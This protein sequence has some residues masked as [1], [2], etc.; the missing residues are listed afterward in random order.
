M[1]YV[2]L[3]RLKK[4]VSAIATEQLHVTYLYLPPP[5]M[6]KYLVSNTSP[7]FPER[8]GNRIKLRN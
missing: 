3:R 1:G 4:S 6:S 2:I 5:H 7:V 8:D